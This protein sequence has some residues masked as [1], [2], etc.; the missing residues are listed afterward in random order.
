MRF[1]V[2]QSQA[3]ANEYVGK[4]FTMK[5]GKEL[6]VEDFKSTKEVTVRFVGT[7]MSKICQL[8]AIQAGTVKYP[9]TNSCI[10]FED[11]ESKYLGSIFKTNEGCYVKVIEFKDIDH[12][13]VQFLDEYGIITEVKSQNL[14]KGQVANPI[15]NGKVDL[16]KL[17]NMSIKKRGI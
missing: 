15:Y 17:K 2:E 9:F 13:V 8:K 11:N 5:S 7:E 12:L 3:L 16:N 4:H 10:A 1:R 14:E 6:V